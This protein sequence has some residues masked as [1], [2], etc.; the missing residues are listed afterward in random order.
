MF[1]FQNYKGELSR[2]Q[3][4]GSEAIRHRGSSLARSLSL[5]SQPG[6]S[7]VDSSSSSGYLTRTLSSRPSNSS[8]GSGSQGPSGSLP[9]SFNSTSSGNSLREET[10]DAGFGSTSSSFSSSSSPN[11]K[12]NSSNNNTFNT[13]RGGQGMASTSNKTNLGGK[14][15]GATAASAAA[16]V[17]SAV[18]SKKKE[19]VCQSCSKGLQDCLCLEEYYSPS[20]SLNMPVFD[21]Q[22][23]IPRK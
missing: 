23:A 14:S 4:S 6:E 13:N 10:E 8:G 1:F 22:L 20:S 12:S 17:A 9:N 2:I 7:E 19:L 18:A 16:A 3:V 5:N 11:T 15:V 21:Q